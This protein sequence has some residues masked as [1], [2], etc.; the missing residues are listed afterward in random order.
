MP[1][2]TAELPPFN[3]GDEVQKLSIIG[4]GSSI[5]V[6]DFSVRVRR[7]MFLASSYYVQAGTI[8]FDSKF[9][10]TKRRIYNMYLS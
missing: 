4:C 3:Q 6:N 2:H 9:R 7:I 10:K 8:R 1:P 5:V